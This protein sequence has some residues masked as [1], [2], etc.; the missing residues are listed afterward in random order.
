MGRG[1]KGEKKAFWGKMPEIMLHLLQLLNSFLTMLWFWWEGRNKPS[2]NKMHSYEGKEEPRWWMQR[3]PPPW[4][5]DLGRLE[6][7]HT[8]PESRPA[9]PS[10]ISGHSPVLL[11]FPDGLPGAA[12]Q[13][14]LG[15]L[16]WQLVWPHVVSS[17]TALGRAAIQGTREW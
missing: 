9:N 13:R 16:I 14:T 11:P 1:W 15:V 7:Q 2:E 12:R 5:N 8:P 4:W 6:N 17:P 3:P 10:P